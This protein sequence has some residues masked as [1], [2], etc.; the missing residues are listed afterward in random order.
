MTRAMDEYL[1]LCTVGD[2]VVRGRVH[3]PEH[4]AVVFPGTRRTYRELEERATTVARSLLGM[5][6]APGDRVGLFMPNRPE[7]LEILFGALFLGAVVVPVNARFRHRELR[8]VIADAELRVLFVGD[9]AGDPTRRADVVT[10]ALGR[11]ERAGTFATGQVTRLH[12]DAAPHLEAVVTLDPEQASAFHCD[13][14]LS[15]LAWDATREAVH[16]AELA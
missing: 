11:V 3:R 8:H 1:E 9:A 14:E 2:L 12:A 4:D 13:Q 7:F 5:G 10:E 16:T 15:R 6:L